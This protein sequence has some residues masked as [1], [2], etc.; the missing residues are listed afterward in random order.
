M[1]YLCVGFLILF[2]SCVRVHPPPV[3][4][5][6]ARATA[7]FLD[8]RPGI[9][10]RVENAYWEEGAS[11]STSQLAAR[12][13]NGYLGT[14][15]AT[16][17]AQTTGN[18]RLIGTESKLLAKRPANQPPAVQLLPASHLSGRTYRLYYAVKF[19]RSTGPGAPI[20]LSARSQAELEQLG[21]RLKA[22]PDEVCGARSSRCTVFPESCTVSAEM[23][24]IVNGSPKA[25]SWGS[26]L[27]SVAQGHPEATIERAGVPVKMNAGDPLRTALVPGDKI[28]F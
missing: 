12:G 7:D 26:I 21:A 23:E 10:L 24:I 25:V 3:A 2:T 18:L 27:G 22:S 14:E 15:I 20:L 5:A 9:R 16:Y 17:Q 4:A 19:S 1:R 28:S 11:K 6:P 13:L 8:L